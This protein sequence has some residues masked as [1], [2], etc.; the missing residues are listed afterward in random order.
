[1]AT[2]PDTATTHHSLIIGAGPA[3]L[4]AAN[5]LAA[6]GLP[7]THVERHSAVGGIWDIGNPGSPMYESAHFISS[8]T[9]SAFPDFPMPDDYPDY[10]SHRQ[11]LAYLRS[12]ADARGLTE[13]IDFGTT[14]TDVQKDDAGAYL[15]TT[16]KGRAKPKTTKYAQ[17]IIASGVQWTPNIPDLP[18]NFTGEIRHSSTYRDPSEFKGKRVLVVGAGNS[19]ADIAC[20]AARSAK[21]A[22]ISVRRGYWFIPKHIFGMP[23]DVFADGGPDIPMWLE[24][25][26]F[27]RM[28]RLINGDVTR[29]GLPKPDHKLFETHPLLN[30]QLLHHLQHGDITARG[31]IADTK[32]KTVTF[33]DVTTGEQTSADFDLILLATGYKHAVPYAQELA[34]DEQQP[35]VYLTAFSKHE[36]IFALSFI[37]TNGAAYVIM[38]QLAAMVAQHIEDRTKLPKRWRAFEQVIATDEPDLQRGIKFVDSPRHT[39]YV[40][41]VAITKYMRKL[42]RRMGWDFPEIGDEPPASQVEANA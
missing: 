29:L 39:G 4:A 14:V 35:D 13:R 41:G 30:T 8:K 11:I 38:S 26:A 27:G 33:A 40:D 42:S 3:G 24:Q 1:M 25:A 19:G 28:L 22:S 32:G 5:A 20:D 21:E 7:Y 12:F 2:T 10:P 16:K 6:R 31:A 34:G 17:V 36:G 9:L 37:E 18:G 23:V 15:V